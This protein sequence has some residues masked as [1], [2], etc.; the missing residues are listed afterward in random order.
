MEHSF[1]EIIFPDVDFNYS[2][3]TQVC[4]PFPHKIAGNDVE[5]YETNPSAGIDITKGVFHCFSCDRKYSEIGIAAAWL[6][7]SYENA[8][9]IVE[10]IHKS[11]S[12]HDWDLAVQNLNNTTEPLELVYKLNF[13]KEAIDDLK[14]GYKGEGITFPIIMFNRLLD[15]VTYTP[16]QKP[17]YKRKPNSTSGLIFGYDLWK[18]NKKPTLICAG[19]KDATIAKS[20]GFNA[21][22]I[23]GGE[24][25]IPTLFLNEFK[26]KKVYI[27]YD[28][29]ETGKMGSETLAMHLQPIA[30]EVKVVDL[31]DVCVNKGEDLWDYFIKYNK[32]S[33]DLITK[34]LKTPLFTQARAKEIKNKIYPLVSLHEA[35]KGQYVQK[36]LRSN[37]QVIAI[38]DNTFLLP[39][40]ITGTKETMGIKE[41]FNTL[42]VGQKRHWNL[43]EWNMKSIF[44]LIDSNLKEK[45]I[46][47]YIKTDLLKIPLKEDGIEIRQEIKKPV[48]KCTVTDV[49]SD[50]LDN[51]IITEFVCYSIDI[52]LEPGKKY[53]ITYRLIPHPQDGQKLMMVVNDVEESDDFISNFKVTD[54]VKENLKVFQVPEFT[55]VSVKFNEIIQKAKGLVNAD[56][57]ETLLSVVDLCYHT[58]LEFHVGNF[59]NISAILDTLV[60]SE[61]RV[62]KSTTVEAFQ[63]TYGVGKTV[64]LTEN[65]ITI[66]GLIGGSNKVGTSFQTRAGV[67]P[68]NHKGLIIFEELAKSKLNITKE[69]TEIRSAKKVRIVRINGNIELP[70]N[71]RMLSLTNT[72]SY[73]NNPKPISS[74][75]NGIEI[76]IDLI[77]T[78]EDIARYDVIAIL[79]FD[80]TKPIDPFFSPEKPFS[81]E[82][83]RSRIHWIWSRKPEQIIITPEIYQYT[84]KHANALNKT[85][86]SHIKIFGI[87]AWKKILR[88]AVAIAGY[89]CSTDDTFENIVVHPNHVDLAVDILI[90]LYDNDTFRFK[91][92]CEEEQKQKIVKPEDIKILEKL[93]RKNPTLLKYLTNTS[94]TTR[95][96]LNIVSGSDS[97]TFSLIMH[98]LVANFFIRVENFDIIPTE[99]FRQ[100]IT[101]INTTIEVL[102]PGKSVIRFENNE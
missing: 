35:T 82:Q 19:E 14:I 29:D 63:K 49:L 40:V 31:S 94:T 38:I 2:G 17:K 59:K 93:Y 54:K 66:P 97:D 81:I 3:N 27:I 44:Y 47:S 60:V 28:N 21:I 99:K 72:R 26:S 101:K 20:Y 92:Y 41:E 23:T 91:Q 45:N 8:T 96:N 51:S 56:Y 87:E 32:D 78:P 55:K 73:K 57:N 84:Q 67:I 34:L 46:F 10:L 52:K 88:L 75:P 100:T 89:V 4:C 71:V 36:T 85:Y 69:L 77:G 79:G 9:K 53:L 6:N 50:N 61:S 24:H 86:P 80:A 42:N 74:Y 22:S 98:D 30:S 13:S 11:E 70:A 102:D 62:G 15:E 76:L 83:Y 64:S 43:N 25:F 90:S 33:K 12:I 68:Q 7:T 39:T 37:V 16:N 48:Y 65:S 1:F 18:N 95:S 58:P 5:Y